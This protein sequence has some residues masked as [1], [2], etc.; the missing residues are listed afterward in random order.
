MEEGERGRV[1]D[2]PFVVNAQ[3][4]EASNGVPFQGWMTHPLWQIHKQGRRAMV[5]PFRVDDL[6]FVV[7]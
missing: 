5:S 2:L 1:D 7:N 4:R 3:T 6:P